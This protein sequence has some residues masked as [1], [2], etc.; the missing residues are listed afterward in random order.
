MNYFKDHFDSRAQLEEE[1]QDAAQMFHEER[2]L[3]IITFL[4]HLSVLLPSFPTGTSSWRENAAFFVAF[5]CFD[6]EFCRFSSE[7]RL[8]KKKKK[9]KAH[10][11]GKE[12]IVKGCDMNLYSQSKIKTVS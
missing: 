6:C 5:Q 8:Y 3:M 2:L 1:P 4:H 10:K 11:E 7:A 9:K 12:I